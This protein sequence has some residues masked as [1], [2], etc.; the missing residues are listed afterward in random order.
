MCAAR[1]EC[2]EN[3]VYTYGTLCNDLFQRKHDIALDFHM[4]LTQKDIDKMPQ[5]MRLAN[6]Q[7]I[8]D[9]GF[10][11]NIE[12]AFRREETEMNSLGKVLDE[13]AYKAALAGGSIPFGVSLL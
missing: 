2:S 11:P 9:L 10:K 5:L 4:P 3:K 1:A 12:E 7:T 13:G 8:A 6:E